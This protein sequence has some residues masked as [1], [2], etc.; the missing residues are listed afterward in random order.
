MGWGATVCGL[1]G[2]A[3]KPILGSV[4]P[5][6]ADVAKLA[7]VSKMTV[8]HVMNGHHHVRAETRAK[9]EAAMAAVDYRP[10]S[11]ARALRRGRTGVIGLAVSNIHMPYTAELARGVSDVLQQY[12][13]RVAIEETRGRSESETEAWLRSPLSYDGL[14]ISTSSLHRVP[15]GTLPQGYPVVVLGESMDDLSVDH[16]GIANKAGLAL[17]TRHLLG[18]G[19]TRVAFVGGSLGEETD[20]QVSRTRG[21]AQALRHAGVAF[22]PA[23]VLPTMSDTPGGHAAAAQ[24]LAAGADGAVCVTD[25]VALGLMRGLA[26]RGCRVPDQVPVVGFDDIELSQFASPTL[27][28]VRPDKDELVATAV[29]MLVE[30]MGGFDGPGRLRVVQCELISRESTAL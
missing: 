16:V 17:A 12:G 4:Y 9:V 3:P 20:M 7:G 21:Y 5:T 19:R 23:L 28:T 15:P 25:S 8:S 27:T 11:T 29:A 10:N 6:M 26:D 18:L 24:V 1:R 13:Y 2:R 14:L 22:D 30:R